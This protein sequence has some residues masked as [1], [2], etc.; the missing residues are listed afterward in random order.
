MR[1]PVT[2]LVALIALVIASYLAVRRTRVDVFP[3]LGAPTIYVA[4]PYSGLDPQQMEGF[5]TYYFEYH[6]LYITGIQ[7]VESKSIQGVSLMK[8][9]FHPDTDLNQAVSEVVGYVNRARAFMPPGAV[10]PFIT[11][12]DAGNVAV[13]QLVFSSP[14]RPP[15]EMQN[16][17]L[18]QVRPLFATLPGVSAPPPF[19]GNQRTM[20]VRL[21]PDKLR[22]YRMA[23]DEAV[24]AVGRANTVMPSGIL[25]ID[26]L[27]RI[28]T[29]NA[30]VG[31]STDELLNSPV[32]S[33]NG[34]TVYLRDVAAVEIGTDIVTGYAH[35]NG[36]RT[37]YIP[38]TK[39]AD[40]STLDVLRR[41]RENLPR[42]QAACPEDVKVE[43]VFDQSGIVATAL[44]SLV[45]EGVLGAFLTGLMVLLFLRDWRSALIVVLTIPV[46]LLGAVLLLWAFG[47]TINIMTL[48]GLAL[49]V[50]VLVDEATVEIENIHTSLAG[51]ATNR[52]RAVLEAARRTALPRF[53][54]MLCILAVFVPSYF[55]SGVGRQLFLPLSL[56]VGFAMISSFLLSSTLVPVLSTW[57]MKQEHARDDGGWLRSIYERYI[58][59]VL[60]LRWL[61]VAAYVLAAAAVLVLVAPRI[62]SELFPA[63]NSRQ[64]QVR[65]R[66]ATGTRI[67]RTELVCLRAL[68]IIR[69][70][71]GPDS[72][73][74][75]TAFIGVQ[76]ASYPI[77]TIHLWT[78][79]PHEAVL[80]VALKQPVTADLQ[81]Q[82]RAKFRDKLPGITVS[83]EPGDIV[84]KVLAFG[85]PTP[86][87]VAVQGPAMPANRAHAA[88]IMAELAKIPELRDLQYKQ[89]L[90]YPTL[91]IQLDRD[92]A[93][94][95]GV[96]STS[97]AK[98]LVAATSSSRFIEP[99]YWRD[100][101]NGN[102]FQIQVE[103]PQHRMASLDD[104]ANLPV[105]SNGRDRP[106]LSDVAQFKSGT[107][108]GE[109]ERYDMQRVV[110]MTANTH[111]KP[112][113][114]VAASI[115][116]AIQRA[117][118]AP[119]GVSVAV[120]GQVP[121][122]EETTEALQNGL[123]LAIGVVFLLLAANFQSL[124]MALAI[125]LT[126]P[127]VLSGVV[128]A[129][130]ITGTTLN[131]QS[132]MG[133]IMAIGIAVANS[134]LL[135]TFAENR[136]R[137]GASAHQA[138]RDGAAGRL[139]AVFMT[140]AAMI[141][142]MLPMALAFGQ[143]SEQSAPLGIAVIGGLAF[144]TLATLTVLPCFYAMLEG[145]VRTSSSASLDPDDPTSQYY[146]AAA[147]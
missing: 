11:R 19:G 132:Y 5:V 141:A 54:S 42:M 9:T 12:F 47:Q 80:T 121:A 32:R 97:I 83:F 95:F 21:D 2:I 29:T 20:V 110:S 147:H 18:N 137:E 111:G 102:G 41:V 142:G 65:L 25:R 75:S 138:A 72:I 37:V 46:S 104:V 136:R 119:R 77:N 8:L 131:L 33:G 1:R 30:N 99:M 36:K 105:M 14:T 58:A 94:Q 123:L 57:I 101:G 120:R 144:S 70:Q 4:Q 89:A 115:R 59:A 50:G 35:V 128:I 106:L 133:A 117:G 31:G 43:L 61:V 112:L 73:D 103:I 45:N 100:P 51:A 27:S 139:R 140:A 98:S 116:A 130:F 113:G 38:V 67:E 129:L 84:G 6:F 15:A 134:I 91:D 48:G 124:R 3:A 13:G 90:D 87:E 60:K 52:A 127:A 125:L 28:A 66:A 68:D 81:E 109:V 56:A 96:S 44:R 122:L 24:A 49:A 17:A 146:E 108:L 88:K 55:M 69:E 26:D 82:L 62:G 40:A 10:P 23:P 114:D 118:T 93:G 39:R 135:I 143:G 79:G 107:T 78:G 74:I 16:I 85:S 63:A 126:I 34:P 64:L 22:Q 86:I 145:N 53:L 92:R 7:H 71:T 76:P